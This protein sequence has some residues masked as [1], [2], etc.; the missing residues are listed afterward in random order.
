ME[1]TE[2]DLRNSVGCFARIRDQFFFDARPQGSVGAPPVLGYNA[3]VQF[4]VIHRLAAGEAESKTAEEFYLDIQQEM[5][6]QYPDMVESLNQ[7][8]RERAFLAV[9]KYLPVQLKL[10][11]QFQS[12]GSELPHEFR[13][14]TPAAETAEELQQRL[15]QA[16]ILTARQGSSVSLQLHLGFR[17]KQTAEFWDRV[18]HVLA[19]MGEIEE[20]G[21]EN[22]DNERV[23]PFSAANELNYQFHLEFLR[24]KLARASTDGRGEEEF[25]PGTWFARQRPLDSNLRMLRITSANYPNFRER[26]LGLQTEIYEPARQSP[27]EEFD[28]LFATGRALGLAV[29]ESDEIVGMSFAGPINA[30]TNERGVTE[31]PYL[32]NPDVFYSMDLTVV[33]KYQKG[34]GKIIKRAILLLAV[35]EGVEAIHGR[36]RDRLA[37]G[38]WAI[39][40]SLGS[41]LINLLRNDYPDDGPYRDCFYYRCPLGVQADALPEILIKD[42]EV[43]EKDWE[44]SLPKLINGF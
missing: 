41:Y 43:A 4:G 38:M 14:E 22:L 27:P 2:V 29:L 37:R 17:P 40:L 39:N 24:L 19:Q 3:S 10:V 7:V 5:L 34:L 8:S 33:P 12:D 25:A 15:R 26:I 28:T 6:S 18:E 9:S 16:S 23:Q 21:I 13:F 20:R 42:A 1:P 32:E 30:F 44:L 31:D 36:N 11:K 35:H